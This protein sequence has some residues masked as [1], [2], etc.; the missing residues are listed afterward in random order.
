MGAGVMNLI[1]MP[2]VPIPPGVGFVVN[3]FGPR[4]NAVLSYVD[5]LLSDEEAQRIEDGVRRVF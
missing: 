2:M 1:H 3:Q 4:M 5:G